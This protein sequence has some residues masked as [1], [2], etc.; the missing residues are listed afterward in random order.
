MFEVTFRQIFVF[1]EEASLQAASATCRHAT[2]RCA[3]DV[4]SSDFLRFFE[5]RGFLW[6]FYTEFERF[7]VLF[8][9]R[10]FSLGERLSFPSL[11]FP[12][13]FLRSLL[14]LSFSGSPLWVYLGQSR[15]F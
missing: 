5:C 1:D 12:V 14:L 4:V 8:T 15:V 3:R 6:G 10:E 13:S 11:R 9:K 7:F 2:G